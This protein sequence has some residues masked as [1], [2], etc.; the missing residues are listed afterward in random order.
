[1]VVTYKLNFRLSRLFHTEWV[2]DIE[3]LGRVLQQEECLVWTF[4]GLAVLCGQRDFE[5][6]RCS[7]FNGRGEGCRRSDSDR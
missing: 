1:M 5:A 6:I 4:S 3:L 2:G 7:Q